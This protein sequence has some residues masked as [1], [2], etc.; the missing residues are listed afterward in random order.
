MDWI[1]RPYT[2]PGRV[3][4]SPDAPLVDIV[5]YLTDLPPIDG[6]SL[7]NSRDLD[8]FPYLDRV[9]GEVPTHTDRRAFN[10]RWAKPLGL[11]GKHICH[12]EW[13]ATGEPWPTEL[14]DTVYNTE[15]V[16]HCCCVAEYKIH[17]SETTI[18]GLILPGDACKRWGG[19]GPTSGKFWVL[20]SPSG[21]PQNLNWRVMR[22]RNGLPTFYSY[23][24]PFPWDGRGT[25]PVFALFPPFDPGAPS[26]TLQVTEVPE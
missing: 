7:V 23:V 17:S 21:P 24:L 19:V 2:T 15:G 11:F 26:Q 20:L 13:L 3:H 5:W 22:I 9:I 4:D 6:A 12:P 1:R 16:P 25:S 14:P 8:P 10:N 18:V